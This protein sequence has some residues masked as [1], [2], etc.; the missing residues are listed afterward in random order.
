MSHLQINT[1]QN[2]HIEFPTANVGFR[3]LAQLLDY[4]FIFVYVFIVS[5]FMGVLQINGAVILVFFLP[6]FFYSFILESVFNGQSFG[7]MIL[8]M[9]V[10]RLDGSQATLLNYFLRWLFWIIDWLPF[11]GITAIIA[12]AVSNKGQRIGDRAA[13]T[14]VVSLQKTF[15]F[16]NSVY[17][18]VNQ[19]YKLQFP[20]VEMLADSDISTINEVLMHFIKNPGINSKNL[21]EKTRDAIIKKTSISTTLDTVTFLRTLV[22]DYNYILRNETY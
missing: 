20:Q 4:V 17:R 8:R 12:I 3:I 6:A 22:K 9:K 1:S 21:L 19:N 18:S 13:G 7:K 15:N 16:R 11:Y 5:F 2:V 10:V 14:T